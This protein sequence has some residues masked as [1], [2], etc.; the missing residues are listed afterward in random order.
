MLDKSI[1]AP[2]DDSLVGVNVG[3]TNQIYTYLYLSSTSY[4][5][6]LPDILASHLLPTSSYSLLPPSNCAN[7]YRLQGEGLILRKWMENL[8]LKTKLTRKDQ[9]WGPSVPF[10]QMHFFFGRTPKNPLRWYMSWGGH[11]RIKCQNYQNWPF[12][13]TFGIVN[14]LER[15]MSSRSRMSF[16]ASTDL[17][18]CTVSAALPTNFRPVPD[19]NRGVEPLGD[20]SIRV[21][22]W[23]A[24]GAGSCGSVLGSAL[25]SVGTL[26]GMKDPWWCRPWLRTLHGAGAGRFSQRLLKV[27][28]TV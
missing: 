17:S 28:E 1:A 12:W 27:S 4:I 24:A 25:W 2:P 9:R 22:S 14:S 16:C 20:P 19:T 21:P 26:P 6:P 11:G 3:S 8:V 23:A 18:F 5:F 13:W 15:R 10:Q 7:C